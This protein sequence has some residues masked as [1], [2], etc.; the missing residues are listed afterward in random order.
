MGARFGYADAEN[1]VPVREETKFR[2]GS[3]SKPLTAAAVGLSVEQGK[4]DLDA[5][6]QQYVLTFRQ[7]RRPITTPR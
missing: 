7:K 2:I 3:V 1:R 4:L 5:P 6:V